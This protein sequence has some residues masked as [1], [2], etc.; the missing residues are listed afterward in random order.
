MGKSLVVPPMVGS[1][2]SWKSLLTNRNTSDDY[3]KT[4]NQHKLAYNSGYPCET[5]EADSKRYL[6]NSSLSQK[7]QLDATARLRG[8]CGGFRHDGVSRKG[9]RN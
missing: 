2:F 9:K 6:S 1:L 5:V 7:H 3:F 4:T 8:I